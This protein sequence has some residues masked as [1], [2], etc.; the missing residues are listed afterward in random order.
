MDSGLRRNDEDEAFAGMTKRNTF[1]AT[2][3][4]QAQ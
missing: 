1:A 4:T 3:A 2:A